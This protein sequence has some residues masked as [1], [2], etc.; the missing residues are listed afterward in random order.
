[1]QEIKSGTVVCFARDNVVKRGTVQ[2]VYN[3]FDIVTV[4]DQENNE[5]IKVPIS[6]L[7]VMSD[8]PGEEPNEKIITITPTEFKAIVQETFDMLSDPDIKKVLTLVGDLLSY[9]IFGDMS[10][11]TE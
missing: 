7:T 5:V 11:K 8:P 4:K 10:A 9:K 1:M 6:D 3:D 2:K